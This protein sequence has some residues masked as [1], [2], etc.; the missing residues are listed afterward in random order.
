VLADLVTRGAT[1]FEIGFLDPARL[2]APGR[3]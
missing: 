1:Q 3:A 2:T